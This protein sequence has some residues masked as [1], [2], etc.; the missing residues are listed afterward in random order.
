MV[1]NLQ[2]S[3]YFLNL[4]SIEHYLVQFWAKLEASTAKIKFMGILQTF[5]QS[6]KES[7]FQPNSSIF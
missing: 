5:K 2:V 3:P 1:T 6:Q 4:L 7:T